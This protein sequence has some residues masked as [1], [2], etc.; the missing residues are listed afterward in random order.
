MCIRDRI[1]LALVG[2]HMAVASVPGWIY[3]VKEVHAPVNRFQDIGRSSHAHQIYRLVLRQ[4]GHCHIQNMV[5]LLVALAHRQSAHCI[6][7][8]VHFPYSPCMLHTYLI[9]H[10]ALVDAEQQLLTVHRVRQGVK[11]LHL[12]LAAR[13]PAGGALH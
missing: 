12:G 13:Q 8:Q 9:H 4:A 1:Q 10:A 3:A 7:V 2:V 11:T 6:T 5:H